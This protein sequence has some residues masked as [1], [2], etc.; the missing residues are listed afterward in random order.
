LRALKG[1]WECGFLLLVVACSSIERRPQGRADVPCGPATQ[2]ILQSYKF[3][4]KLR[5]LETLYRLDDTSFLEGLDEVKFRNPLRYWKIRRLLAK[6]DEKG[7]GLYPHQVEDL[8]FELYVVTHGE[9]TISR[10]LR[11]S[12]NE[13]TIRGWFRE[14]Y[15]EVKQDY[16]ID[17]LHERLL[18][19]NFMKV[20]D[21][22][23]LLREPGARQRLING[24]RRHV[25]S[26]EFAIGAIANG[27]TFATGVP[28]FQFPKLRILDAK[29]LTPELI[30]AMLTQG[31]HAVAIDLM[32][33]YGK[34]GDAAVIYNEIR[35]YGRYLALTAL[36][37]YAT[38]QTREEL[39][40][41]KEKSL[42]KIA[43]R[44]QIENFDERDRREQKAIDE[45]KVDFE[46][47]R[48]RLPTEEEEKNF[49]LNVRFFGRE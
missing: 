40:K 34:T 3:R 42:E 43:E 14:G 4:Q 15:L 47:E 26:W 2:E 24:Y 13:R 35:Y 48:K 19:D 27:T 7:P 10:W 46:K 6:I 36:V 21:D 25:N 29:P 32:L 30:E 22:L 5:D 8:V 28:Y 17:Y 23:G 37:T 41:Q 9:S 16:F 38:I 12:Q 31:H 44:Q 11:G 1:V 45:W 39:K 20:F 49:R 18:R 33:H